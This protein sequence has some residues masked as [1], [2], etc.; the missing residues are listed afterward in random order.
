LHTLPFL[1]PGFDYEDDEGEVQFRDGVQSAEIT[2][3]FLFTERWIHGRFNMVQQETYSQYR[4]GEEEAVKKNQK[5]K[6][7]Q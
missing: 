7:D 5:G 6:M 1:A 4:N 3:L 2:S